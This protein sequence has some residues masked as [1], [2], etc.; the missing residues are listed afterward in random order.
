MYNING[1]PSKGQTALRRFAQECLKEPD[2]VPLA[3]DVY[4]LLMENIYTEENYLYG[5]EIIDEYIGLLLAD[6]KFYGVVDVLKSHIKYLK[7]TKTEHV[8]LIHRAWLSVI[9]MYILT[10]ETYLADDKM[11]EFYEDCDGSTCDE[12]KTANAMLDSFKER[13]KEKYLDLLRK[14]IFMQLNIEIVKK[15]KKAN[16]GWE[17][18][19]TKK[20]ILKEK[21]KIKEVKKEKED[22]MKEINVKLEGLDLEEEKKETKV[23]KDI[24]DDNDFGGMF[25]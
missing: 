14:P 1:T 22:E 18:V 15:L 4:R 20:V 13:M 17:I 11:N 24:K 9:C 10:G 2:K 12:Y 8:H 23:V 3:T 6:N 19:E 7:E 21:D 25:S 5:S 16:P